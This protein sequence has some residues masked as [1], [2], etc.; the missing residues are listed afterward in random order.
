MCMKPIDQINESTTNVFVNTHKLVHNV[1]NVKT[2][3]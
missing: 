3:L 2:K 1:Y